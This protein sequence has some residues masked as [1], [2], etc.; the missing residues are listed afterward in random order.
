MGQTQSMS[1]P[2]NIPFDTRIPLTREE[3]LAV[4]H[5]LNAD[6]PRTEAL[7]TVNGFTLTRKDLLTLAADQWLNDEIINAVLHIV[8]AR[9]AEAHAS[10]PASFPKV[11]I[12]NSFFFTLLS[13]GGYTYNSR[14]TRRLNIN[15]FDY[16][17]V[18]VPIHRQGNHWAMAA[19][20]VRQHRLVYYDSMPNDGAPELELLQRFMH[21]EAKSRAA[22]MHAEIGWVMES[23]RATRGLLPKQL[24]SVD[25]GVF[26][27][28]FGERV[29]LHKLMTFSQRDI[30]LLRRRLAATLLGC[31]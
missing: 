22:H 6:L 18:L 28:M 2:L 23:D 26:M 1:L 24:N 7:C 5:A 4:N 10:A 25:C 11:Y 13:A 17:I 16:D 30:P 31:T 20:H 12:L 8:M 21:D 27:L 19:I 9:A 15:L 3:D 14:V 29:A